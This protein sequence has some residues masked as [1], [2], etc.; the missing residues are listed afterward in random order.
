M[1]I[2][3]SNYNHLMYTETLSDELVTEPD[4]SIPMRELVRRFTKGLPLGAIAKPAQFF[5]TETDGVILEHMDLADRQAYIENKQ[6][7]LKTLKTKLNEEQ[8]ELRRLKKQAEKEA[9]QGTTAADVSA[10][11]KGDASVPQK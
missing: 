6:E 3:K 4:K 9:K 2:T 8:K 1:I 11:N 7:E 5:G 10:D